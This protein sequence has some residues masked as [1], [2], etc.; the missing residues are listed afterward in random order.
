MIEC[1][2]SSL[3]EG[4]DYT[5]TEGALSLLNGQTRK[6]AFKNPKFLTVTS[7]LIYGGCVIILKEDDEGVENCGAL[8]VSFIRMQRHS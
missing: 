2:V 6:E 1:T 3:S 4:E 7:K 5:Q 8:N